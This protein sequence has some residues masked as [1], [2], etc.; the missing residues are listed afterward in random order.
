VVPHAQL[1]YQSQQLENYQLQHASKTF[2]LMASDLHASVQNL[3]L[4]GV[5]LQRTQASA[6]DQSEDHQRQFGQWP[7]QVFWP[8]AQIQQQEE[9]HSQYAPQMSQP[10]VLSQQPSAQDQQQEDCQPK[11]VDVKLQ[12]ALQEPLSVA[13][14]SQ[15]LEIYQSS[16]M[17]SQ[18]VLQRP[19]IFEVDEGSFPVDLINVNNQ[20]EKFDSEVVISRTNEELEAVDL[21]EQVSADGFEIPVQGRVCQA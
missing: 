11:D 12:S 10:M 19:N 6:Q 17:G 20:D 18:L 4:T 2:Q 15:Q 13:Y 3:Q 16:A 8:S 21:E 1:S 7:Q 9:Q 14:Q 5:Q